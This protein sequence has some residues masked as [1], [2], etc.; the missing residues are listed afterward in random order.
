MHVHVPA[1]TDDGTETRSAC[2]SQDQRVA[3][4]LRW[5]VLAEDRLAVG[6]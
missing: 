2:E 6:M 1:G 4:G 5:Q 3:V